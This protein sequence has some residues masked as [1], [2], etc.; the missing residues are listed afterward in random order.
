MLE[1]TKHLNR[2]GE[3]RKDGT[4]DVHTIQ[5]QIIEDIVKPKVNAMTE[6]L[7]AKVRA[8]LDNK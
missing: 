7:R 2:E 5:R 6:E 8:M 1:M 4:K 3:T